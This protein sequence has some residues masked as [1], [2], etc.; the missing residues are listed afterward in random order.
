MVL[1]HE[2]KKFKFTRANL[3]AEPLNQ[4]RQIPKSQEG[5]V[6]MRPSHL[7]KE[8]ALVR[9]NRLGSEFKEANH[10]TAIN[11]RL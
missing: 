6:K 2:P 7:I 8:F 5:A 4:I 9:K 3:G 1:I 10:R 11:G